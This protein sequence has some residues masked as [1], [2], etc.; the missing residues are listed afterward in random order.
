MSGSFL[1]DDLAEFFDKNDF[2]DVA[3]FG[4]GKATVIFE[5]AFFGQDVGGSVPVDEGVPVAHAK[6]AEV[7]G[8]SPG[9]GLTINGLAFTVVGI[10]NDN[11]GVTMLRL[12]R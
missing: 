11:T 8:V 4:S 12:Q 1:E 5:N 3:N 6:S 9:T 2:G 7:S 10:E